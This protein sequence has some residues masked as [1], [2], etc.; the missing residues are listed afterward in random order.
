M[1]QYS[2]GYFPEFSASLDPISNLGGR[3]RRPSQSEASKS[4]ALLGLFMTL[5]G[6]CY[7]ILPV[8][9]GVPLVQ[10]T[11]APMLGCEVIPDMESTAT[12]TTS[13]PACA[14]ANM[15]ATPAPDVS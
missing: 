1:C 5:E 12:S 13:A 7:S 4:Q 14:Q 11:R 8:S 6:A 3:M 10:A 9:R 2:Q 15:A